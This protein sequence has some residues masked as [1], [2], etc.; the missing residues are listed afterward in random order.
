MWP[1]QRWLLAS[2]LCIPNPAQFC[3]VC[4]AFL[5]RYIIC[6]W[7]VW[8]LGRGKYLTLWTGHEFAGLLA[9]CF[10]YFRGA[11][12]D[13]CEAMRRL[14]GRGIRRR[15][16][17]AKTYHPWDRFPRVKNR[18]FMRFPTLCGLLYSPYSILFHYIIEPKIGKSSSIG[19]SGV[20]ISGLTMPRPK[21][22]ERWALRK[23]R[24]AWNARLDDVGCYLSNTV[25]VAQM[26]P[27]FA[28]KTEANQ[29]YTILL[30]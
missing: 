9:M 3:L 17:R 4:I 28:G 19:V 20:S 8:P 18:G 22:F 6:H 12:T 13:L 11:T 1:C 10:S 26:C 24:L 14:R 25:I 27:S 16:I 21:R 2:Q 23:S 15:R 5:K 29:S 7:E 30:R